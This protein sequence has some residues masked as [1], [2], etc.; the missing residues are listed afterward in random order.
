VRVCER[1][2][3]KENQMKLS[4]NHFGPLFAFSRYGIYLYNITFLIFLKNY[5]LLRI[6]LSFIADYYLYVHPTHVF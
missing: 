3:L 6:H 5:V 1:L 2:V 4:Y